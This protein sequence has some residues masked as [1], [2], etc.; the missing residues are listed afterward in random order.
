MESVGSEGEK[1]VFFLSV[2][3]KNVSNLETQTNKHKY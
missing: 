1:C 2:L 3:S